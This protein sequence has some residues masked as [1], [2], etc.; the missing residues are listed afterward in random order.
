MRRA[1]RQGAANG[2][3]GRRAFGKKPSKK[4]C[5]QGMPDETSAVTQ[6]EGPGITST[7]TSASRAASTSAWPG[8]DT[9]GMPA[10]E[11]KARVSPPADG[12][13]GRRRGWRS[14]SRRN[15]QAAWKFPGA[16]AAL[17]SH[18]C[19]RS[20]WHRR[21]QTPRQRAGTGR[22]GCRWACRPHRVCPYGRC[23]A[24][25][26][27][28]QSCRARAYR[29]PRGRPM[30]QCASRSSTFGRTNRQPAQTKPAGWR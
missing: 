7:G 3:H 18:A 1:P 14:H 19:L 21:R 22:P 28:I 27:P 2:A 26:Q 10:S 9:L 5:S 15:G 12:R 4:K 25:Y 6:A 13:P 17:T 20:K 30:L 24:S 11:A 29:A 8:S 23:F 16:S